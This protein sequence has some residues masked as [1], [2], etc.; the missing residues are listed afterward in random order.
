MGTAG[1]V[2]SKKG[3]DEERQPLSA[4]AM[5]EL[6]V[7]CPKCGARMMLISRNRKGDN[8]R[9]NQAGCLLGSG[10]GTTLLPLLLTKS[11]RIICPRCEIP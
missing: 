5:T 7:K 6:P 1:Y 3:A 9:I 11:T 4:I 10:I 8:R 2:V